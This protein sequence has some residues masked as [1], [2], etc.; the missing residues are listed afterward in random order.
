MIA[1]IGAELFA[2][3]DVLINHGLWRIGASMYEIMNSIFWPLLSG[4]M[5]RFRVGKGVIYAGGAD[6]KGKS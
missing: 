3:H 2:A 5:A 4:L 6:S 1:T